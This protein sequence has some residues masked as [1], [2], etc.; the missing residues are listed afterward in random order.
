MVSWFLDCLVSWFLG[1]LVSWFLGFKVAEFQTFLV[2]KFPGFL[3]SKIQS[4]V[5]SWYLGFQD[6][7]VSWYL[8]LLVSKFL[9]FRVSWFQNFKDLPHFHFLFS[10]RYSMTSH[11][12]DFQQS[13]R[14]NFMIRRAPSFPFFRISDIRNVYIYKHIMFWK[15]FGN[16][17]ELFGVSWDLQK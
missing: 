4:F 1:F 14:R 15:R 7:K 2:S 11:I 10:G 16:F 5:V 9:G 12:Q 6:F 17:L 8:G 3:V 13:L